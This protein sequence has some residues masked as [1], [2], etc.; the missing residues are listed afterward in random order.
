MILRTNLK[1]Y[2]INPLVIHSKSSLGDLNRE[3]KTTS[4]DISM[5]TN[6]DISM[7]TNE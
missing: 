5:A 7:A 1:L 2:E 4:K 3:R 6:K